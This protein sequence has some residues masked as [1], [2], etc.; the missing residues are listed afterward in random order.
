MRV[1]T[2]TLVMSLVTILM[3]NG[4]GGDSESSKTASNATQ[5]DTA[6]ASVNQTSEPS[7]STEENTTTA[8]P[9][10]NESAQ[11]TDTNQDDS[12][13]TINT[14]ESTNAQTQTATTTQ[15]NTDVEEAEEPKASDSFGYETQRDVK[16]SIRFTNTKEET[17]QKQILI[18][19]SKK[20]EILY[21]EI[22]I[23]DAG[24]VERIEIGEREV[25]DGEILAGSTDAN[26]QL[27]E[28]FTLG[29]HIQ[30]LWIVIPSEQY[31]Q[32][33]AI[34]NNEISLQLGVNYHKG[35]L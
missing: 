30:S 3:L 28:T 17:S 6:V 16:I 22:Q 14:N 1:K 26:H 24:N 31:E 25:F 5:D 13:A 35:G 15:D 2:T 8:T 19:E 23:D 11:T 21:D 18:Y 20:T 10:E 34:Q 27:S 7:S 29:N 12:T 9:N 4:C 33:I 32:Q